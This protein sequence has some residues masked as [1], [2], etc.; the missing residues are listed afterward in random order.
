MSR[1][2]TLTLVAVLA[3]GFAITLW[4][5]ARVNTP[6]ASGAFQSSGE[7]SPL[8]TA[9]SAGYGFAITL[10]GVLLGAAYRRLV[11][12]RGEGVETIGAL[13]MIKTVLT[14]VDFQIG[15]VGAPIIYG[16]LW[17]SLADVSLVGLTVIALQNGF[18]SH[19]ILDQFT[20]TKPA[21]PEN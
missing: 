19:A 15:I 21:R 12:L 3:V 20:T 4:F 14:S 1:R 10:F 9:L 2:K 6:S 7:A 17:Q 8:S 13:T 16:L 11:K 18:A 5:A